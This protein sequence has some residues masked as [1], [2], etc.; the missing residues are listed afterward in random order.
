MHRISKSRKG[1]TLVEVI[2]VIA[3]LV[4]LASVLA[5]S[6]SDYVNRANN[7]KDARS[8]DVSTMKRG[9]DAQESNLNSYG[10]DGAF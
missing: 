5:L 10:F 3:I 7:A 2:L 6:V 8:S 9:I 1:F 4:I